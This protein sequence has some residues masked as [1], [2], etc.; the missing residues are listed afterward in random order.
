MLWYWKH[1]S[2]LC[3]PQLGELMGLEIEPEISDPQESPL[4]RNA[5]NKS[6]AVAVAA[7]KQ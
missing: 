3:L 5:I 2:N 6:K 7:I 4:F 1:G